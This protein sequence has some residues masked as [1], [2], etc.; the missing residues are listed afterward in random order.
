MT[1]ICSHILALFLAANRSFVAQEDAVGHSWPERGRRAARR[2]IFR[3]SEEHHDRPRRRCSILHKQRMPGGHLAR[4][5][6]LDQI[7]R[8]VGLPT[9]PIRALEVQ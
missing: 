3:H 2:S 9:V 7:I 6:A 4:L 8:L 1:G 5:T